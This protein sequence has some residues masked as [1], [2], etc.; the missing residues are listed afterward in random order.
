MSTN[1]PENNQ[2][3]NRSEAMELLVRAPLGELMHMAHAER[4]RRHPD[5]RVTFVYDTNPNYTNVCVTQCR[6]CAFCCAP[7]DEQAFTLTP[8]SVGDKVRK[9]ADLGATTV[10]L[11]GGHNPE[12]GLKDWL[13][14][15]TAIQ[16]A[17]PDIHIHPFSP[18]EYIFMAEQEQ[19]DV[20]EVL[21]AVYDAGV[22]TIPGG[23]A[24]VLTESVR[25]Q[26][27]PR[28]ATTEEWLSVCEAAHRI[29]FRTTATLM[30]G[31]VE[32]DED[33]VEHLM[34]LREL[35]DRTGGFT[36]F[37][38]WS[39][40]PG[41]NPLG[42]AV[43]RSVHPAKYVRV[44]ATARLVL[45]N[46][47]HVQSSWFSEN[48]AA[49]QLGLLAGADDFGGILVEENVLMTAGHQRST[50]EEKVKTI[51]RRTGFA[52]A[53][54]NSDYQILRTFTGPESIGING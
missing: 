14:Y 12:V 33:I 11:Q 36:S 20:A 5:Q 25:K 45:D 49:G 21:K 27:A 23:G 13:N 34:V 43:S 15:I 31:H 50:T 8:E 41:G 29:G 3:I 38:P 51:I 48:V 18:A 30:F 4:C 7:E 53:Q 52:P 16:Q 9:A 35:Q 17:A 24:E 1:A 44:I 42:K 54:R 22:R 32:T 47:D 19:C 2:R 39:Y 6:F 40:K 26:I 37:I 46:F 28:K 10:L